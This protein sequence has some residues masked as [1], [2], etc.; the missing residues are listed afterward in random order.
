MYGNSST[1]LERE[2]RE[3]FAKR[4][5]ARVGSTIA[6]TTN[7]T[8]PTSSKHV[9]LRVERKDD[10]FMDETGLCFAINHEYGH[11]LFDPTSDLLKLRCSRLCCDERQQTFLRIIGKV[12]SQSRCVSAKRPR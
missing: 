4:K 1:R 12:Y 3:S 8:S 11:L 10:Y 9:S 6:W 5:P 7:I 2:L